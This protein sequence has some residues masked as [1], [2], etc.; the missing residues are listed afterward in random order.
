MRSV[1]DL[2]GKIGLNM[3]KT[4][5]TRAIV[6]SFAAVVVF[7]TT[8]LL[9]LPALTLEKDEADKQAGISVPT[10]AVDEE[11]LQHKETAAEPE[12]P[13]YKSGALSY[14]GKSFEIEA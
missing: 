6:I 9:I 13:V 11:S 12:T 4:R 14:D 1:K 10:E 8:Y 7:V 3:I 2:I 5:R